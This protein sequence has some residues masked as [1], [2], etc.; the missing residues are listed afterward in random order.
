MRSVLVV[1]DDED[2]LELIGML[3]THAGISCASAR[4]FEAV[5][6]MAPRLADFDVALVDVNLGAG[7]PTGL[8]VS[9]FLRASRFR[10]RTVFLTG[11]AKDDPLLAGALAPGDEILEKPVDSQVLLRIAGA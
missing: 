9:K 11:H 8:D 3:F 1:D 10:G 6:E 4:S 5:Q 2:L 7:Q